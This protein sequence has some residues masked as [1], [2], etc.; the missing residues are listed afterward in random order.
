MR[1]PCESAI[2]IFRHLLEL[3]WTTSLRTYTKL[4]QTAASAINNTPAHT[5]SD[6]TELKTLLLS[7]LHEQAEQKAMITTSVAGQS[8]QKALITDKS[9]KLAAD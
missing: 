3:P 9:D 2:C 4:S 7:L 1:K 5:N 6:I 8:A